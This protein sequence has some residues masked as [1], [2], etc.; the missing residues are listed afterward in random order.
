MPNFVR[1]LAALVLLLLIPLQGVAASLSVLQC[2]PAEAGAIHS[3]SGGDGAAQERDDEGSKN[4]HEH[5]FCYQPLSGMPVIAAAAAIPDSPVFESSISLPSSLF[6]PEQ[7]QRP[8]FT[9]R[10]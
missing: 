8:P 9:V 6:S 2:P 10:A 4:I 3:A 7:P 1:K 5:F